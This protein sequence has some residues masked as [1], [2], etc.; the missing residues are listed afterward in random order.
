M[1]RVMREWAK[2]TNMARLERISRMWISVEVFVVRASA[3]SGSSLVESYAGFHE[4]S[5]YK[6]Q[7]RPPKPFPKQCSATFYA[8]IS[9]SASQGR[10]TF[11]L[12]SSSHH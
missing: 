1:Q 4:V 8:S 7:C 5:T 11:Y 9:G 10:S 6:S 3:M 2:K 12:Y